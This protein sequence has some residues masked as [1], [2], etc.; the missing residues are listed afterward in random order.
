MQHLTRRE[1][2]NLRGHGF[3]GRRFRAFRAVALRRIHQEFGQKAD[4]PEKCHTK[5][6]HREVQTE[7]GDEKV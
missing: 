6:K 1:I 3:T 5:N 4:H 7:F 2:E